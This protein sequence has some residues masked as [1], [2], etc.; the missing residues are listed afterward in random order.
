[1]ISDELEAQWSWLYCLKVWQKHTEYKCSRRTQRRETWGALNPATSR[2]IV[3]TKKG[4]ERTL[5]S[6]EGVVHW[7]NSSFVKPYNIPE[8]TEN[9]GRVEVLTS[10]GISL[11]S[12][13]T[14]ETR[15]QRKR[16][17]QTI[18]MPAKLMDNS[19]KVNIW[20]KKRLLKLIKENKTLYIVEIV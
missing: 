5:K 17:N 7:G 19:G 13:T 10:L 2:Y 11:L 15:E 12:V 3:Q 14:S 16:P 1:M 18:K 4:Q 6:A 20:K 8:E 9:P